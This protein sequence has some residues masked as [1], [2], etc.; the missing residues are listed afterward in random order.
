MHTCGVHGDSISWLSWLFCTLSLVVAWARGVSASGPLSGRAAGMSRARSA[1]ARNRTL[2]RTGGS[3]LP[4]PS[5]LGCSCGLRA[6]WMHFRGRKAEY[7]RYMTPEI[8]MSKR[9]VPGQQRKHSRLMPCPS[10]SRYLVCTLA[11]SRL[12]STQDRGTGLRRPFCEGGASPCPEGVSKLLWPC[13]SCSL[14][15]GACVLSIS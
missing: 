13:K 7:C 4:G 15:R 6:R 9:R 8:N 1:P 3:P 2:W 12:R 11:G 5:A 14:P 10:S